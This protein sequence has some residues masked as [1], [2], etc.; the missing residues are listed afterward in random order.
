MELAVYCL[1]LRC[2]RNVHKDMGALGFNRIR[3]A[4][5]VLFSNPAPPHF[6]PPKFCMKYAKLFQ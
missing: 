3:A 4:N 2:V 6:V 5:R 1:A